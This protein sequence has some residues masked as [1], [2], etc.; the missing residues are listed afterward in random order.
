MVVKLVM[1]F[2]SPQ[3]TNGSAYYIAVG[4]FMALMRQGGHVRER[5]YEGVNVELV[6]W[7]LDVV[8]ESREV[9]VA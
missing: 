6:E 4:T 1:K 9:E 2:H 7:V 5:V 3:G 8:V